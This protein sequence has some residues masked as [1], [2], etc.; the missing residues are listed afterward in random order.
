MDALAD[1]LRTEIGTELASNGIDAEI[2]SRLVLSPSE[3][4]CIDIDAGQR[5]RESAGFGQIAGAYELTV[6][7]RVTAADNFSSQDVLV[8]MIDDDHALCVAA[9]IESDPT[10][11]GWA[12]DVWVDPDGIS[13][14]LDFSTSTQQLVGRTWRVLVEAAHS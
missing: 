8:D 1:V 11:G 9:A 10:L 14:T 2:G 4:P 5:D 7:A 6:R 12:T 3:S 13:A